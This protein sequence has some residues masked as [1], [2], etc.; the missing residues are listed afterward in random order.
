MSNLPRPNDRFVE[1]GLDSFAIFDLA[2][3]LPPLL[4]QLLSHLSQLLAEAPVALNIN[5]IIIS[6][7]IGN[8]KKL[9]SRFSPSLSRDETSRPAGAPSP[10]GEV[11][12][13]SLL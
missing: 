5:I 12:D 3:S 11:F 9:P 7:M 13:I 2:V 1:L 4:V 8:N 10:D 6:N